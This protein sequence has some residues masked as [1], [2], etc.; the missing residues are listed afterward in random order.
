MHYGQMVL[1]DGHSR[2]KRKKMAAHLCALQVH[3]VIPY[4]DIHS[5]N[6]YQ[7]DEISKDV[8]SD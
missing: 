3:V 5:E 4:L 2:Y 8:M 1:I 7:R 6:I